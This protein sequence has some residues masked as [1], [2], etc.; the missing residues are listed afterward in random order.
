MCMKSLAK[1]KRIVVP[2]ANSFYRLG[3]KE[4][5]ACMQAKCF[6][7]ETEEPCLCFVSF[8]LQSLLSYS[9]KGV[10]GSKGGF[11]FY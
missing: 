2:L 7:G 4:D 6:L 11:C 5:S 9:P 8:L 10:H 3:S 1:L